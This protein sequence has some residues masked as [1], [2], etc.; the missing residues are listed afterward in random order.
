MYMFII[1]SPKKD[2]YYKLNLIEEIRSTRLRLGPWSENLP[3]SPRKIKKWKFVLKS[4]L[5]SG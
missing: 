1:F 4:Y 5:T 2:D 3:V